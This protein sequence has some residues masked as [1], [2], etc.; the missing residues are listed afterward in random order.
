LKDSQSFESNVQAELLQEIRGHRHICAAMIDSL[1]ELTQQ[2]QKI[3]Q[4]IIED[5]NLQD[6]YEGIL[7]IYIIYNLKTNL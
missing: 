5:P 7:K 3:L 4:E 6:L 1:S 2:R